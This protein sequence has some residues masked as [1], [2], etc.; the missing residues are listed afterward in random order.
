MA[1]LLSVAF[2]IAE[3][4][5]NATGVG[6]QSFTPRTIHVV[7][8]Q[9]TAGDEIRF[10]GST[11]RLYG[12]AAP[13][14]GTPLGTKAVAYLNTKI[15][16]RTVTCRLTGRSFRNF[17]VGTCRYGGKDIAETLVREGL[18]VP[19]PRLGGKRYDTAARQAKNTGIKESFELPIYCGGSNDGKL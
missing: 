3:T 7:V 13:P 19:C 12:I 5:V 11:I 15:R 16:N 6:D 8:T 2:L 17:E 4:P 14:F 9:I 1:A 18:A 10:K